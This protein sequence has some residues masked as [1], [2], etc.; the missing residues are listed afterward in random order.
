MIFGCISISDQ[1]ASPEILR[2]IRRCVVS[3]GFVYH[4]VAFA[5]LIG[6]YYLHERLPLTPDDFYFSDD[7]NDIQVLLSGFIYNRAELMSFCSITAP[8]PDPELIAGMFLRE[9]AD[10]VKRLNGDFAFCIV[11]PA[12][13]QAYLYRD[14]VGIRPMAWANDR[15]GIFFSTDIHGLCRA[16]Y[17]GR[18]I[19]SDYLLGTFKY[20]DYRK[21]PNKKVSKVLPGHYLSVSQDGV[22]INKYWEPE[23][24]GID[25]KLTYDQMISD[26]R[27]I[28]FDAVRI[29]CD[30]RF[31]AG[32][33]VSSGL[34]SGI[35]SALA[36]R[37]YQDQEIFNGF[38]WS[39]AD[40]NAEKLKFDEREIA[41]KACEKSNI[42]L[43]LSEMSVTD[44]SSK[45]SSCYDNNGFYTEDKTLDQAV[46]LGTNLIFSGWGGDEFIS[47]GYRGLDL[48][49]LAGI[50]LRAFFRRNPLKS[51]RQ[52]VKNLLLLVIYPAF[53]ILD[54]KV[55]ESF[56]DDARYIKKPFKQSERR[57]LMNFYS[58]TSR[59][60]FHLRM[61]EFYGIQERCETW[62]IMGYRKGIEYRYPLLD[63]RIIE[64]MLKVPSV[65]LCKTGYFRPLLREIGEGILAE[66]VR[67][68]WYKNDPVFWAYMEELYK[69]TALLFIKEIDDWRTSRD[70]HFVDFDL[71]SED[72]SK[73][74]ENPDSVDTKVLFRLLAYIKAVYEFARRYNN[75]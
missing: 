1:E 73:F 43:I 25:Y 37:E 68:H 65:L 36:R 35:V 59:H 46:I 26:L 39:P 11:R 45:V 63:K 8:V 41:L 33:H 3:K 74:R 56:R 60:Q 48:D 44:F 22:R 42:R 28:L 5:G 14:H 38:S 47:T 24:F 55:V 57:A 21:T 9:G 17:D 61:L 20:I 32:A 31:T 29:R 67:L 49:L 62:C 69:S 10:F 18:L 70:L 54:K 53:G 30:Y 71:L 34:D 15:H 58:H 2:T 4:E 13:K 23:S 51:I 52:F 50:K 16:L 27:S 6:G 64:Y 66:E 12:L 7:I 19:D 75:S 72:I 40:F